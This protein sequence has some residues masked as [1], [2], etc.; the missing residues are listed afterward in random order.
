MSTPGAPQ[1]P[2]P[3]HPS[4]PIQQI[5]DVIE[6]VPGRF[7]GFLK[8]SARRAFRLRIEPTEVLPDERQALLAAN[9]PIHD[10]N[11]QAFLAWRRS[12]LFLVATL[13]VPLSVIGVMDA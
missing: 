4:T 5:A 7:L 2:Q 13:L 11:L 10:E 1:G 9:P 6:E 3:D 8:I 12:V